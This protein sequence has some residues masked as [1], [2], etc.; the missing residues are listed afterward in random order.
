MRPLHIYRQGLKTLSKIDFVIGTVSYPRQSV[1]LCHGGGLSLILRADHEAFWVDKVTLRQVCSECCG[2]LWSVFTLLMLH[3]NLF[4]VFVI[5]VGPLQATVPK[6][7]LT[8][9]QGK[10]CRC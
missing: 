4:M 1:P 7:T 10:K 5:T 2:L 3:I 8:P 9:P 6:S